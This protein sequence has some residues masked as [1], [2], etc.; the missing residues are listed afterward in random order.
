[1][2]QPAQLDPERRIASAVLR[3]MA[4]TAGTIAQAS[5]DPLV[6]GVSISVGGILGLV[7]ALVESVGHQRVEEMLRQLAA[8]PAKPITP[9]QLAA[10]VARVK[11]ELGV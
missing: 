3:S 10:D 2:N 1:M 6:S 9:E 11:A 4:G 8:N 5:G 7:A